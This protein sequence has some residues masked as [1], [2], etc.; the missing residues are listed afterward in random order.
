MPADSFWSKLFL[1]HTCPLGS[2]NLLHTHE[3]P[4]SLKS[5]HIIIF[6]RPS[7]PKTHISQYQQE[8]ILECPWATSHEQQEYKFMEWLQSSHIVQA[9]SFEADIWKC[10]AKATVAH[11]HIHDG[12][13]LTRNG[14]DAH[15]PLPYFAELTN[16]V[17]LDL[18]LNQSSDTNRLHQR[19]LLPKLWALRLVGNMRHTADQ[20]MQNYYYYYNNPWERFRI[21]TTH[22][23]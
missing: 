22:N 7:Q 6:H 9:F 17:P 1:H 2:H 13:I 3:L 21:S 8:Q 12:V 23:N 10:K 20:R 18:L 11:T 19:W 5:Y 16:G 15:D 14:D 4:S